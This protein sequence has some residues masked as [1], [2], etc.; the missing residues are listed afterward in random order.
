[1]ARQSDPGPVHATA[2]ARAIAA[3]QRGDFAAAIASAEAGLREGMVDT[4]PLHAFLGMIHARENRR[5]PA[6]DHLAQAHRARPDDVTI[7]CNLIA[8]LLEDERYGDAIEVAT[9]KLALADPSR[10]VARYRGFVAQQLERFAEAAD[11]YDL[12]LARFPDDFETLNNLGNARAGLDDHAG[13]VAALERA[14][15]IDPLAAPTR[16]NLASALIALD[17]IDAAQK[18]LRAATADFPEDSRAPYQLYVHCKAQLRQDEALAALEEAARRDPAVAG[19]QLKLGVEYG[20]MRRTGDAEAAFRQAIALEPG[21]IDAYLG[22]AIQHEHMNREEEFAPLIAL[23]RSNG[24]ED[25]PLAF[26]EALELR[27]TGDFAGALA[28]L[29]HVPGEIEP[30][31]TVHVRATLLERLKRSDEA[32]AA[33]AH[34]NA[35]MAESAT[36]PLGRAAKLRDDLHAELTMLSPQWVNSW[37]SADVDDGLPDP[38][39]LVGFPRSG[40]TLLDTM[41]MGHPA[42]VVMEEQPP[43]NLVEEALGG[44]AGIPALTDDQIAAARAHYF[45]E[46]AKVADWTPD[47]LLIDKSP[48]YLY[49]APLIR[50]LFPRARF[51]L[52]LRHPC[53]VVLSCF[54]A[55]FRLNSA[56]ANFLRL[57]DAAA[58]YDVVFSHWARAAELLPLDVKPVIY[59]D[60]IGD[61]EGH[62]RPLADWLGLEWHD[63][64]LDHQRTAKARGL[65]T[66]A[67]YSQVTEPIYARAAGRWERYRRHLEPVLPAL[68]PWAKRF[69]YQV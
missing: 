41:L 39:I 22:L 6:A 63:G 53:D 31:R 42:A 64:M 19:I 11:A 2:L 28:R 16:L 4:A 50:R 54:M 62:L 27:R 60:L 37:H 20:M 15:A 21:L 66:T 55:N 5:A 17:R 57:E 26:I 56:M 44:Q 33:Y 3:A 61:V 58:F 29:D 40:T 52:A 23:A 24:V 35:M 25:G 43:L 69:G 46:V 68:A 1:M 34:A 65:I 30:V 49:R 8:V 32:F 7:A 59:E 45:A 48:L 10:R 67:S 38:V 18:V 47:R 36:D 51:I 14:V 9:R 12:V 13:A